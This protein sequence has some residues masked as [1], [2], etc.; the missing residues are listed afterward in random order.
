MIV[1]GRKI[2]ATER[3]TRPEDVTTSWKI[4]AICEAERNSRSEIERTWKWFGQ[5]HG[6][7]KL[8]VVFQKDMY[9]ATVHAPEPA[10]SAAQGL[11]L[12]PEGE[13]WHLY[14]RLHP[15]AGQRVGRD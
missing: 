6:D 5:L 13:K 15:Y 10:L 7:V 8:R 4:A 3:I 14:V 11:Q 12:T 2:Y 9:R 1:P